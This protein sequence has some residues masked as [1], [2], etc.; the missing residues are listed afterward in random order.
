MDAEDTTDRVSVDSLKHLQR[1]EENACLESEFRENILKRK[2]EVQ[3]LQ[4]HIKRLRE[5]KAELTKQLENS[6]TKVLQNILQDQPNGRQSVKSKKLSKEEKAAVEE[7]VKKAREMKAQEM[8]SSCRLTGVSVE[9]VTSNKLRIC[10]D[11]FYQGEFFE[12]FY[13]EVRMN[14]GSINLKKHSIPFFIPVQKL[15]SKF[16]SND[17]ESFVQQ[18]SIHLNSYIC[19]RQQAIDLQKQHKA[20]LIGEVHTA[21]A[22]DFI[23]L[24]LRCLGEDNILEACLT[25]PDL[26]AVRPSKVVLRV[27]GDVEDAR[28]LRR[29][30]VE[31]KNN[32]KKHLL[33]DAV[34]SFL[35]K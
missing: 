29:D 1:L 2:K 17:M 32:L 12:S 31:F 8:Y 3:H 26:I 18:V 13:A 22:F 16:L 14:E 4:E 7:A 19:R 24:Y 15:A 20:V 10:W 33:V 27:S 34:S 30:L 28:S 21:E 23:Q 9:P 11:T 6:S 25:Y 35:G 5:R